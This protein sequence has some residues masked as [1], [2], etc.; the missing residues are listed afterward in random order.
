MSG[1]QVASLALALVLLGALAVGVGRAG[2]L[3]QERAVV[4]AVARAVVQVLAVGVVLGVVL[5]TPVLAPVYLLVGLGVAAATSAR[6]LAGAG[7]TWPATAA[8]IGAGAGS[9]AA[10]VLAC[11]ALEWE[12]RQVVPFTAQLV[13]GAMTATTLA[14]R[15]L[16]DDA[17]QQW[18]VVE[19]WYA[20]G[21]G[22]RQATAELARTAAARSVVPALDQTRNVGLVVLP[23]AFVGLL[24]AGASPLEAAR[25]QLL[26]LVGLLAAETVAAVVVTRLLARRL[27]VR[28]DPAG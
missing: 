25:V 16:L 17:R 14:G 8:A 26:V 20:L 24:L 11:R 7:R 19:G 6:R 3:G 28:P 12:A 23:G 21:A 13:G 2:R 22:P 1:G 5:A 9:A 18:D 4:V 27:V 10:V 15:R